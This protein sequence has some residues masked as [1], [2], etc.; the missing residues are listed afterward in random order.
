ME[1]GC[2]IIGNQ[3]S[4][5]ASAG[6]G[7]GT[8]KVGGK[9]GLDKYTVYSKLYTVMTT[10]EKMLE[11]IKERG[12][13]RVEDLRHEFNLGRA[14]LHRHLIRLQDEGSVTKSGKPPLV[15]YIYNNKLT[16]EGVYKVTDFQKD[17]LNK[18]YLYV[19]PSG[20]LVEGSV[21]F[22]SWV[23]KIKEEK[24]FNGL[25]DEYIKTRQDAN[26]FIGK[27]GLINATKKL[28]GTFSNVYIDKVYFGDF[29]SLPKFG[30][31]ILGQ[32]ILY[33]KQGQLLDLIEEVSHTIKPYLIELVKKE[34]IDSVAFIPP[35]IPRTIQFLKEFERNI[36][37]NLPKVILSKA[38][39][40]KIPVA[41]KTLSKLE[42]RIENA[43][44]TIFVKG[45]T[46]NY[47]N[48]LLIDDA[49]GSG[50]TLNETAA[51]IKMIN[52]KATV[53]GFAIVGSYKGFDVISEV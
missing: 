33:A 3:P 4:L 9:K 48:I 25:V 31:T 16:K 41:Q 29:Y 21:G 46:I 19:S 5:K 40:G 8:V 43:K 6:E 15:F 2:P 51:K 52:P 53:V 13:T 39:P 44:N 49:V 24:H 17:F 18:N 35:T 34:K 23:R 1:R 37:L 26:K 11:F 30:K 12:K 22:E 36:D 28:E 38:Y 27:L 47:K 10:R 20:E 50:S 32:K 7:S 45:Q 14:I 42:E